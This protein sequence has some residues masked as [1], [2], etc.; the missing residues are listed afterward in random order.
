MEGY[1]NGQGLEHMLY[2]ERLCESMACSACL[3]LGNGELQRRWSQTL[4]G[5]AS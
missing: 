5:G 3:P 2:E 1:K 4:L